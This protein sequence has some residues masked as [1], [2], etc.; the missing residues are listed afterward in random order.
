MDRIY[1]YFLSSHTTKLMK[2]ALEK[3]PENSSILDVGIGTGTAL[4]QN[5]DLIKE[6][7]IYITGIDINS[8]YLAKCKENIKEKELERY[9]KVFNDDINT[10]A[11]NERFDIILFSDSFAVIPNIYEILK[12]CKVF[13]SDIGKMMVISALFKEHS[14][15]QSFVKKNIKYLTFV[16]F[17]NLMLKDDLLNFIYDAGDIPNV[18]IINEKYL[19]LFGDVETYLITW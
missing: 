2:I 12:E 15:W 4:T 7:N 13:L 18:D 17:G 9:V 3:I 5:A 8:T 14:M 19:Y 11:T 1:D 10:F 6:K 16:E